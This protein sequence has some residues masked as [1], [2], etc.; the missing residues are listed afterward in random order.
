MPEEIEDAIELCLTMIDLLQN[1]LEVAKWAKT[2]I[3][4]LMDYLKTQY[5]LEPLYNP[6]EDT[7]FIALMDELFNLKL[8]LQS[9]LQ[10][11]KKAIGPTNTALLR[12]LCA[13]AAEHPEL[14]FMASEICSNL[15]TMDA[16]IEDIN[17]YAAALEGSLWPYG[18]QPSSHQYW[19][20]IAPHLSK[21]YLLLP[22][23]EEAE[24]IIVAVMY[25]HSLSGE[26]LF[27]NVR[28]LTQLAAFICAP[29]PVAASE[30]YA[31]YYTKNCSCPLVTYT[32]LPIA[33]FDISDAFV[34]ADS[35][36]NYVQLVAD[37]EVESIANFWAER[38][39]GEGLSLDCFP[40]GDCYTDPQIITTTHTSATAF[41][42][43]IGKMMAIW[44]MVFEDYHYVAGNES[45]DGWKGPIRMKRH[46]MYCQPLGS[47]GGGGLPIHIVPIFVA[48]NNGALQAG[49]Q[50]DLVKDSLM[51]H[52]EQLEYNGE[53]LIYL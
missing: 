43:L 38:R 52:D 51:Y 32:Y 14:L 37:T 6:F 29:G 39:Q 2:L 46:E 21:G 35:I 34:Y 12:D 42:R 11:M 27:H 40:F 4:Q 16:L 26:P 44:G 5:G 18:S 22:F 36:G 45:V 13:F 33:L 1:T 15:D 10:A 49:F 53:E 47:S 24:D 8:E 50:S 48:M 19:G 23:G 31:S 20:L 30:V 17:Q 25:P 3:N 9:D 41:Q 7:H 28:L